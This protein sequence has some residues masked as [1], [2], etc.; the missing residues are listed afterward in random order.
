MVF[1]F[2]LPLSSLPGGGTSEPRLCDYSGQYYCELCHWNDTLKIPARIL[3]NWDFTSYK[4]MQ[5]YKRSLA[6]FGCFLNVLV[7]Y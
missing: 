4:V 1:F 5:M 3:H 2:F 6:W 7:N